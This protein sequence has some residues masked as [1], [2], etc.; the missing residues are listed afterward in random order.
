MGSIIN[1]K[2]RSMV[3]ESNGTRVIVPLDLAEGERYKEPV[4][5]E[6]EVDHIYKLTAQDED[7]INPTAEGVLY[8]ERIVNA[9]LTLMGRWRIGKTSWTLSWCC[10][11][12]ES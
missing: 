1:L 8:W 12:F 10:G 2:K 6:E 9:S 4:R 5:D 7:W 3:V 11:V